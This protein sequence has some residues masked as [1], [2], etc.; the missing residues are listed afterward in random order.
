M[1]AAK[2]WIPA[3]CFGV[4]VWF[5]GERGGPVIAAA[6]VGAVGVANSFYHERK[7]AELDKRLEDLSWRLRHVM[8]DE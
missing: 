8:K 2:I 5:V 7:A 3:I 6:F 4:F 1:I